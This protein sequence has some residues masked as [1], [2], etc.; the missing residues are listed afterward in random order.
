M[1]IEIKRSK[2]DK[3]VSSDQKILIGSLT[4]FQTK[5]EKVDTYDHVVFPPVYKQVKSSSIFAFS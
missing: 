4:E 2:E 5:L 3:T 1:L